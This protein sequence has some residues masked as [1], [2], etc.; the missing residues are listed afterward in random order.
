MAVLMT[1]PTVNDVTAA[2]SRVMGV[3]PQPV[4]P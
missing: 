4:Q 1:V 2:N 3:M